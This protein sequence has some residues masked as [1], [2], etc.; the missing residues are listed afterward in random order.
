MAKARKN[1]KKIIRNR[2]SKSKKSFISLMVLIVLGLTMFVLDKT[3]I[4][5]FNDF[6][7][8]L[9]I[10]DKPAISEK[11]DTQVHFL[12]VGQGDSTIVISD[13]S[14]ML[15]DSGDR[16][17]N[18][19]VI[20]HLKKMG[21]KRLDYI[22]ITHPHSDHIGEMSEIID[23]FDVGKVI[24]MKVPDN[25]VPTSK[26]YENMLNSIKSKKLKI[27]P[28]KDEVFDFGNT[29]VYLYTPKGE[30]SDLNNY[31]VL[32]KIVHEDNSFLITGDCEKAEEKDMLVQSFDLSAKV[33]KVGHHGSS[34]SSSKEFLEAVLPR[35][36]VISCG[37]DN[38]YGHPSD[39]AISRLKKY[40]ENIYIT[41]DDEDIIFVSDGKGLNVVKK[42]NGD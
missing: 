27:S 28:A 18:N 4:F 31:S 12:D 36:A 21:I 8:I 25:K 42:D 33:L 26:I 32:V 40:S 10:A 6:E 24:M 19:K 13:E 7:V 23:S 3:G 16:D 37:E 34:T 17:E 20:K 11:A 15:I 5:T 30:Y 41:R 38:K 39:E 1:Q 29:K 9:G 2:M 22:I 14:T 35:Y